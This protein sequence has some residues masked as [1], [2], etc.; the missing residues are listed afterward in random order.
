MTH[1]IAYNAKE[2]SSSVKKVMGYWGPPARANEN[3]LSDFHTI[4]VVH[5]TERF[6]PRAE[7]HSLQLIF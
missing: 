3:I 7:V 2:S 1:L 4:D 6:H 5:I